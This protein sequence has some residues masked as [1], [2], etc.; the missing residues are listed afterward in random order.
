M[1]KL[2][3]GILVL[4]MMIISCN[5][6]DHKKQNGK[7]DFSREVILKDSIAKFPG[8]LL[9]KEALIQ[10]YRD[11][12]EYDK[13]IAAVNEALLTDSLSDRL[14]DIKATLHFENEDTLP[15][16]QCFERALRLNPSPRYLI[17]LG[18]L[19]AQNK[20]NRALMIADALAKTKMP[21]TEKEAF[22]ITGLYYNYAGNN[23]AAIA[24][25]D[26]CLKLDDRHMFAYR[27][28]AIAFY[29][30]GKYEDALNVVN[31]AV[32]LQNNFDEGYYWMGRCLEKL[33]N[34]KDAIEA[35][36]TALL[37]TPDYVEAKE[38]LARLKTK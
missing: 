26:K 34:P 20:N 36:T 38:A 23:T 29:D 3:P 10:L 28:K 22:F 25:L 17:L 8:L 37:Y 33:N 35:Y 30:L 32:N 27:E 24:A 5:N 9:P 7:T 13:A 16:I 12:A 2:I 21:E 11:S 6:K 14:W 15:A 18:S 19:Y 1:H 4:L 31:K